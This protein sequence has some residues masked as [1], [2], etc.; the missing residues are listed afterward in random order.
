MSL[1]LS[2]QDKCI[3][4]FLLIILLVYNNFNYLYIKPMAV[5]IQ[6]YVTI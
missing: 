3:T 1:M 6:Y 2:L 4:A 5:Y